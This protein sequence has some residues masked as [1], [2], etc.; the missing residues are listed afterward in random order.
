MLLIS[1]IN[2]LFGIFFG[3]DEKMSKVCK[4]CGAKLNDNDNFCII[5]N[6]FVDS[7]DET[8]LGIDKQESAFAVYN[9]PTSVVIEKKSKLGAII[10]AALGI[11]IIGWAVYYLVNYKDIQYGKTVDKYYFNLFNSNQ[12]AYE[13]MIL[14]ELKD[15]R[16]EVVE[17]RYLDNASLRVDD[18]NIK[19]EIKN[20]TKVARDDLD[21]LVGDINDLSGKN[22]KISYGY[23]VNV[24]IVA[25]GSAVTS[26]DETIYVLKVRGKQYIYFE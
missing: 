19:Y 21:I 10:F 12:S 5:C 20:S 11:L 9:K 13:S 25:T 2:I 7:V 16:Y 17:R 3:K 6:K 18:P 15:S 4:I 22:I 24:H 14:P 8:E 1:L 26:Y 23:K